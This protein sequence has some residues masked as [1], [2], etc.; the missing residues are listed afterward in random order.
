MDEISKNPQLMYWHQTNREVVSVRLLRFAYLQFAEVDRWKRRKEFSTLCESMKDPKSLDIKLAGSFAFSKL[1]D[2]IKITITFENLLKTI[3]LLNNY[4]VHEL[5]KYVFQDKFKLQKTE[6]IPFNDIRLIGELYVNNKIDLPNDDMKKQ[7][8][9]IS[10]KTVAMNTLLKPSYQNFFS[11][12]KD[13]V[14]YCKTYFQYRNNLHLY[15]EESIRVYEAEY[16]QFIKM[17]NFINANVVRIHNEIVDT[18]KMGESYKVIP[19]IP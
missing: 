4:L 17:V 3:L 13:I 6:P 16:E 14:D 8:K 19:L 11:I 1:M 18:L 2:S 5:N 9:G 7:I 10:Y 12:D 15:M